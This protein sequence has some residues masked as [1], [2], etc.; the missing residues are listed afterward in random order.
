MVSSPAITAPEIT[1]DTN[2]HAIEQPGL[3]LGQIEPTR[4]LS[5]RE[6]MVLRLLANG[7]SNKETAARLGISANTVRLHVSSILAKLQVAS[8]T[9][10]AV[11][12]L[13]HGVVRD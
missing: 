9:Q 5:P 11:W 2:G 8:R 1:A 7:L 13:K 10:A 3:S 4:E 12:A 6:L